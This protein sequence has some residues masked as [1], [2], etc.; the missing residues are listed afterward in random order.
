ML[1]GRNLRC[2]GHSSLSSAGS[3][4]CGTEAESAHW[5]VGMHL[6]GA[7]IAVLSTLQEVDFKRNAKTQFRERGIFRKQTGKVKLEKEI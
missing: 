5:I 1:R 6:L 7:S 3:L 2:L 4:V